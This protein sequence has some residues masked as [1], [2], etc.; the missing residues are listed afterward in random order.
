MAGPLKRAGIGVHASPGV[1]A[2]V[3]N[4]GISVMDDA[5]PSTIQECLVPAQPGHGM[6]IACGRCRDG[7]HVRP[8]AIA[9]VI[10]PGLAVKCAIKSAKQ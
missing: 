6:L 7:I 8:G 2:Q 4:P 9:Q 10:D 3:I 5:I 1:V